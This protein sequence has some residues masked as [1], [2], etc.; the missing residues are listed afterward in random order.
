MKLL[1]NIKDSYKHIPYTLKHR[2]K[3]LELEKELTGKKSY[4]FHDLDKVFMYALF[5]YLGTKIIHQIHAKLNKHHIKQKC[6]LLYHMGEFL[7]IKQV[8]SFPLTFLTLHRIVCIDRM[9][10]L[11]IFAISV[12]VIS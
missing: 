2:K 5:P 3:L 1:Q 11:S 7:R 10:R 12:S 4:Y 9:L 8:Y 6:F